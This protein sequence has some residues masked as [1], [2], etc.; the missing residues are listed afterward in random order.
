MLTDEGDDPEVDP[1][2][3]LDPVEILSK[4]PK[5]FYDK[6][7]AK[8]WQ[9]RKEA[10]DALET[11]A[12]N[13]KLQA[14]DYGDLIRIL[15]KVLS[16]DTNVVLVAAAGKCLCLLAKGLGKKFQPYAAVCISGA[17]EKFKEKKTNVVMA[18]R[19]AIDAMYPSTNLEAIQEDVLAALANK[20]PNVK[21]ETALFI[22][23]SLTKTQPAVLNKKLLKAYVTA[24]LKN[25]CE[26]D[27]AVRESSAEALGTMMKLLGDKNMAPYLTDVDSLKMEKI[28]E[29]CEKAVI[30]VKIPN[31]KKETRP[32]TAPVKSAKGGSN[33]PRPVTRPVTAS[34]AARKAP[35]KKAASSANALPKSASSKNVLPTERELTPEE[36]DEKLAEILPADVVSGLGDANWKTRLSAIENFIQITSSLEAKNEYS[37]ILIKTLARKPGLKDTNFQVLKLRLDA[38]G[39]IIDRFGITV[40]TSDV[41]INDVTEKLADAKSGSSAAAVLTAMAESIRLEYVVSKVMSFSFEQKSPKVQQESLLWVNQAIKEFGFQLNPK[42]MIDDAK[43]GVNSTTPTVRQATIT[44]LGTMFLYMGNT[45]SMFFDGEKPALRQLIQTEF[46]KYVGQKPPTPTRGSQVKSGN[47][48][49][50]ADE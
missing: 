2:D 41:I 47:S 46:D 14:G 39:Q 48:A 33:E 24:L 34:T 29:S 44:L 35:A 26:S 1:N 38:V 28:K 13:P 23:R 45:L 31:A 37:Q 10:I 6:I 7:E 36:I 3:F 22:A 43:K 40:T 16:K 25:L 5:D 49:S 32:Q 17:L 21:T 8:K 4:L 12:A 30:I 27:P 50:Y 15:K 20:N 9:D 18:L 11:L 42:V 19:D